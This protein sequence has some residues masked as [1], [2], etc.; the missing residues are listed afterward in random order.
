VFLCLLTIQTKTMK[1]NKRPIIQDKTTILGQQ[2]R[3]FLYRKEMDLRNQQDIQFWN[4]REIT[5]R[6]W[7]ENKW[8]NQKNGKLK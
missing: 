5:Y 3:G 8:H 4:Q 7:Q 1:N 2:E 6:H